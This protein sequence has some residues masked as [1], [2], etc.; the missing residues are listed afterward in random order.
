M[1]KSYGN[2]ALEKLANLLIVNYYNPTTY[3]KLF[4]EADNVSEMFKQ[5]MELN[6]IRNLVS[7]DKDKGKKFSY[8]DYLTYTDNIFSFADGLVAIFERN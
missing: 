1:T 8:N 5:A 6:R 7:H 4:L 2:G 3:T